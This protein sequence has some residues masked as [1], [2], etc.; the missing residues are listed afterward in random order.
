VGLSVTGLTEAILVAMVQCTAVKSA[1]VISR[2]G[3][4]PRPAS[5]PDLSMCDYFF[6]GY[7]KS[8]VYLR[9]PRDIDELKNAVK[10]QITATPY[11]HGE[12]T[13]V[14]IT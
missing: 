10:E 3:A 1:F 7:L 12:R 5:S 14:K 8:E 4:I 6:W 2:G 11:K 13:N 9:K